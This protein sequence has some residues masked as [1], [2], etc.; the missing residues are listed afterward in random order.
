M[1]NLSLVSEIFELSF[2][3]FA[4]SF[5]SIDLLVWDKEFSLVAFIK[6]IDIWFSFFNCESLFLFSLL[7]ILWILRSFPSKM[8]LVEFL[9]ISL[10]LL[11]WKY[12]LF[13]NLI[14][15]ILSFF[16]NEKGN[17]FWISSSIESFKKLL[18][19]ISF[20]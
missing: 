4:I 10:N 8:S 18:W 17:G 16:E 13:S 5:C 1:N 12:N 6:L 2:C 19:L 14:S 15:S 9:I 3:S 11:S 7:S 20:W